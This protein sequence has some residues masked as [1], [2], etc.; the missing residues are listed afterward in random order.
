M[1][2]R[3]RLG[4]LHARDAVQIYLG[5]FFYRGYDT[6]GWIRSMPGRLFA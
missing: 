4:V 3:R 2:G 1:N 6:A 5:G